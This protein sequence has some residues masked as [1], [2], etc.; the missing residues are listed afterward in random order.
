MNRISRCSLRQEGFLF[1]QFRICSLFFVDNVLLALLCRDLQQALGWFVAM[2]E[3][4]SWE[5]KS[6]AVDLQINL[7]SN[8]HLR[9]LAEGS[10]WKNQVTNTSD[11]N[12]LPLKDGWAHEEVDRVGRAQGRVAATCH[13]KV[14]TWGGFGHPRHIPE[15]LFQIW[16]TGRRSRSSPGTSWRDYI[17]RLAWEQLRVMVTLNTLLMLFVQ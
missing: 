12:E 15:A 17:S 16:S 10:D 11:R 2:C 9:P 8:L 3:A 5:S 13:R 7:C 14:A 1:S 6:E 4:K